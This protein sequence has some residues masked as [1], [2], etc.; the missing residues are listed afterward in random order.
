MT[1]VISVF[2]AAAMVV[3]S[4]MT[5]GPKPSGFES[6]TVRAFSAVG[7]GGAT[8]VALTLIVVVNLLWD[9]YSR[10]NPSVVTDAQAKP[11]KSA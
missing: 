10:A 2:C 6:W 1:V 3:V 11:K 8:Y 5:L 4:N 7:I 9:A